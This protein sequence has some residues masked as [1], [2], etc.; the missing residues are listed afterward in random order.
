VPN[1]AK[2]QKLQE[3]EPIISKTS[4][5]IISSKKPLIEKQKI[6]SRDIQHVIQN[7]CQTLPKLKNSK[8]KMKVHEFMVFNNTKS[9]P[10]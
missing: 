5:Q 7:Q 8:R 4:L 3:K 9:F 6:P 10:P 1:F 2:S